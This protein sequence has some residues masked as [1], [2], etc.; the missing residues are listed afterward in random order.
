MSV[1]FSTPLERL[2]DGMK[3]HVLVIPEEVADTFEKKKV[4]RVVVK[5][6]GGEYRRAI[7]G[8]KDGRRIVVLGQHILKECNLRV[9]EVVRVT[10]RGDDDP[11]YVDTGEELAEVLAQDDAAR[12]RWETFTV[13]MQRSLALYVTQAK[14][15]DTRIKRALELVEKIRTKTLHGDG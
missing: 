10:I 5:I 9:G 2:E 14:R 13:G 3:H 1:Q 12:A 6:E 4:K 11:N 15:S 7:Q 8:K